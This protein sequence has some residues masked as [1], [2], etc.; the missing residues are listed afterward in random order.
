MFKVKLEKEFL[1]LLAE[2]NCKVHSLHFFDVF[3]CARNV[4]I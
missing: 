2:A 4:S 1:L 3:Q